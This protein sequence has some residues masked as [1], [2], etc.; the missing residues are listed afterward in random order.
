MASQAA[1]LH[2]LN[3]SL[4]HFNFMILYELRQGLFAAPISIFVSRLVL[5]FHVKEIGVLL[6]R[7]HSRPCS[8]ILVSFVVSGRP[9]E[10]RVVEFRVQS[11]GACLLLSLHFERLELS[12]EG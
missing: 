12:L 2:L 3:T 1:F 11:L 9:Y 4:F 5:E 10:A 6:L 7:R 8:P